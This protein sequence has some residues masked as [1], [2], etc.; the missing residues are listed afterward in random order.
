MPAEYGREPEI[1]SFNLADL[2]VSALDVRLELT[3]LLPHNFPGCD[4]FCDVNCHV[5]DINGCTVNC[6]VN[7]GC[8]CNALDI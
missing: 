5:Y 8:G 1:E 6:P 3:T 2:D 7:H 4:G